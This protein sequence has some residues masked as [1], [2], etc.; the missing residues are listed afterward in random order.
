[1]SLLALLL[2]LFTFFCFFRRVFLFILS[3]FGVC[4]FFHLLG[5]LGV[6][7]LFGILVFLDNFCFFSVFFGLLFVLFGFFGI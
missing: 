1:M 2:F 4:N 7:F 6:Q 5:L 3:F